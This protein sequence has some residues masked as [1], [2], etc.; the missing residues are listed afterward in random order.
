M[1]MLFYRALVVMAIFNQCIEV[2]CLIEKP[3]S[4]AI[5]VSVTKFQVAG[6]EEESKKQL[7]KNKDLL[8]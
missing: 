7:D 1:P 4:L 6:L 5:T 2:S 3:V 8:C